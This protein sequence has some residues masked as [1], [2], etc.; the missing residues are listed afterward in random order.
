MRFEKRVSSAAFRGHRYDTYDDNGGDE[1]ENDGS[2]DQFTKEHR[3]PL[4]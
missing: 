2:R 1:Q 4:P 3:L